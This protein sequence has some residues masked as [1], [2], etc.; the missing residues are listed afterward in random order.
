MSLDERFK[1]VETNNFLSA[2]KAKRTVSSSSVS[3]SG[4]TRSLSAAE[5]VKQKLV[6]VSEGTC[7]FHEHRY[8]LA[9][10]VE[11][12]NETG[13]TFRFPQVHC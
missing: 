3:R 7:W 11:W 10:E 2:C 13:D 5:H 9:R 8:P 1:M 4:T 6:L 12:A